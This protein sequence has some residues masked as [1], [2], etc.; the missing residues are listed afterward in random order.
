MFTLQGNQAP[1]PTPLH[2]EWFEADV[3]RCMHA[4]LPEG[5]LLQVQWSAGTALPFLETKAR[6]L[7]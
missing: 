7:A 6:V 5:I 4:C 2:V 3:C 1:S